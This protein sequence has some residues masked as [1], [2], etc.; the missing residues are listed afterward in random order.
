MKNMLMNVKY[1][2]LLGGTTIALLIALVLGTDFV[3]AARL[4]SFS[5]VLGDS[6]PSTATNMRF[7]FTTAQQI[8]GDTTASDDDGRIIIDFPQDAAGDPFAI[9]SSLVAADISLVSGWPANVTVN[10]VTLSSG[11]GSAANDRIT[12]GLNQTSGGAA[13]NISASTALVFDIINNRIT[14]PAKVAAA[15]TADIYN[16][17][18]AT[19]DNTASVDLDNGAARAAIQD[20]TAVTATIN[21][22]L[23]FTVAGVSSGGTCR[24]TRTASA[25]STATTLP[26]GTLAPNTAKQ[27]CQTL[28]I[29]TNAPNGYALYV[30][31]DG[32]LISGSDDIDQ[33]KDGTRVDDGDADTAW[34]SPA[35]R[36]NDEASQGHLGY[37]STDTGVFGADAFA[38][39]PTK[40][41][42]GATPV[43]TGLACDNTAATTSDTCTVEYKVEISAL[44]PAGTTYTNQIQ[45]LL[46]AQY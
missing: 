22:T 11:G 46:V 28:T 6:K 7:N 9:S 19:R 1:K 34:T 35:V 4:T 45:Y 42:A 43:T 31:Q 40:H 5:I 14:T 10:S 44:Q 25:A 32:N 30:V 20:A 29:A 13:V 37:G 41:A 23:T 3:L 39:I 16:M 27:L 15:G 33:F 8:N 24:S 38:G 26:F 2:K 17:S 21:T 36:A 18:L 12:I